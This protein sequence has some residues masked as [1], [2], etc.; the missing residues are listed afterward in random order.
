[1]AV[2]FAQV[3]DVG[4]GNLEDPQAEQAEHGHKGKVAGM[5]RL[6]GRQ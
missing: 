2:L 4:A 6:A 1:V 3:G 5:G